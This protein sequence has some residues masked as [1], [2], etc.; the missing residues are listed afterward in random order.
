MTAV[1]LSSIIHRKTL[2]LLPLKV[3]IVTFYVVFLIF[4][5]LLSLVCTNVSPHKYSCLYKCVPT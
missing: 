1:E 5:L 4:V 3:I 2:L